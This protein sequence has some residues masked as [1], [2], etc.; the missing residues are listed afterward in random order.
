M[1]VVVQS[2][3]HIQL[4]RVP[5]TVASQYLLSMDFPRQEYLSGLPF[6]SLGDLL[7][8]GIEPAYPAL[9]GRFLTTGPL[10]TWY[11]FQIIEGHLHNKT[12]EISCLAAYLSRQLLE[13][14]NGLRRC[15]IL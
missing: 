5:R 11:I 6:P 14:L 12:L 15:N 4:L 9:Q 1:V 8:S 10:G 7:D 13:H 2:L 3:S